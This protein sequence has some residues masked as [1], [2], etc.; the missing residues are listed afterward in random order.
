MLETLLQPDDNEERCGVVLKDGTI[1]EIENLAEDK[2]NSF[3]MN[4]SAVLALLDM[5]EATWHTHPHSDPTLSG[6]DHACFT[7]W[8]GLIHHVIGR[9]N[10]EV[11]VLTYR[12]EGGL[13]V[14]CD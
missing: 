5:I 12:V 8:P 7:A 9:R 2:T 11:K 1:V 13:V 4:P 3:R 6:D 14:E 10:N